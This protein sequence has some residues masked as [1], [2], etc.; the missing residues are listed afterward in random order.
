MEPPLQ[1]RVGE[2]RHF[3]TGHHSIGGI[4]LQKPALARDGLGGQLVIPRNHDHLDAGL[5]HLLHGF[6]RFGPHLV[7]DRK[8]ADE[9]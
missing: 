3:V 6:T 9:R 5:L 7:A 4:A 8:K 2:L 1:F